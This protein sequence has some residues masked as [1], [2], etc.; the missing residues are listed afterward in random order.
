MSNRYRRPFPVDP[1]LAE[2]ME[3]SI[4]NGARRMIKEVFPNLQST[5]DEDAPVCL[6]CG[7]KLKSPLSR[8][9]GY[10]PTCFKKHLQETQKFKER[11]LF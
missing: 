5:I 4:R 11:R 10:G 3:Q 2:S 8:K 9:Q 1:E 6:R 7:K